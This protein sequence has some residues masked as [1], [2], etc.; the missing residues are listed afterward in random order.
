MYTASEYIENK[1]EPIKKG[2]SNG[3]NPCYC[4]GVCQE[5]TG[6]IHK[7]TGKRITPQEYIDLF[8]KPK[9]DQ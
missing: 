2:C 4:T 6:Y 7:T 5:V 8:Y 9:T 3:N 1:Y